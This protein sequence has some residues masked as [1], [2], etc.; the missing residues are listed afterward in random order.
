MAA[1]HSISAQRR[2]PGKKANW[3]ASVPGKGWFSL[4]R[5]YGPAEDALNIS[6]K[7]GDF[8]K[9]EKTDPES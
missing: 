9:V 3:L 5:L 1:Q 6:R 2:L 7:P 4:L 8:A